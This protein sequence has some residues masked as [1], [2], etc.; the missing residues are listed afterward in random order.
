LDW[1]N[2][3]DGRS[4]YPTFSR[5]DIMPHKSNH[6]ILLN[7]PIDSAQENDGSESH[8]SDGYE[9]TYSVGYHRSSARDTYRYHCDRAPRPSLNQDP[10]G[11]SNRLAST[12]H[13]STGVACMPNTVPGEAG[14]DSNH[15]S[16]SRIDALD[17]LPSLVYTDYNSDVS[18]PDGD[19][20]P[21]AVVTR[22][23][24]KEDSVSPPRRLSSSQMSFKVKKELSFRIQ[25]QL[26]IKFEK[27]LSFQFRKETSALISTIEVSPGLY[28]PLRGADE[29]WRAIECDFYEPTACLICSLTIF[30]IQDADYVLCPA[31]RVVNP[32]DGRGDCHTVNT[33]SVGLGFTLDDLAKWQSEI[34]AD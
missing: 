25:K 33:G 22:K 8:R 17:N 29:T 26:S 18:S 24:D 6:D 31:C 30:C 2:R 7:S 28:L 34:G 13:Y 23:S 4:P 27:E 10:L 15:S 19:C 20:K 12:Y 14:I 16:F 5:N 1:N 32:M 3:C 9:Y 11:G 21:R